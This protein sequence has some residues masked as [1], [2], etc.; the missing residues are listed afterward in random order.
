L[1]F[2]G[3]RIYYMY[4]SLNPTP[5]SKLSYWSIGNSSL[6]QPKPKYSEKS[7]SWS[8]LWLKYQNSSLNDIQLIKD[9]RFF[10][11]IKDNP[12]QKLA[13]C[14]VTRADYR[15]RA[16]LIGCCTSVTLLNSLRTDLFLAKIIP[17]MY[18]LPWKWLN[19]TTNTCT[20]RKCSSTP[21]QW[22]VMSVG[23]DNLNFL[24]N[25]CVPALAL[26]KN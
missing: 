15:K 24:G 5:H 10:H 25:F 7:P 6:S 8:K 26:I 16:D 21:F 9:Y 19:R 1:L 20:I 2:F 11:E 12:L 13:E 4:P 22:M 14:N 3:Y 17:K 23:C 18:F